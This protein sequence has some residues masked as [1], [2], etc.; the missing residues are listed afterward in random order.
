M[1]A[2][3]K[4]NEKASVPLQSWLNK[5]QGICKTGGY[6][7]SYGGSNSREV[8]WKWVESLLLA[9]WMRFGETRVDGATAVAYH[10][11]EKA[12]D[13]NVFPGATVEYSAGVAHLSRLIALHL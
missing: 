10:L 2:F 13:L 7:G 1:L 9:L 3:R 4:P 6:P 12:K 11:E 8:V 5:R